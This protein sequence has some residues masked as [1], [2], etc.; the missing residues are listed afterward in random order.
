MD[1][2]DKSKRKP[3]NKNGPKTEKK[4]RLMIATDHRIAIK[5]MSRKYLLLNP[6]IPKKGHI[7]GT[8]FRIN[9]VGHYEGHLLYY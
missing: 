5:E 1:R 3:R 6:Q 9:I 2:K 7:R 8:E 4:N